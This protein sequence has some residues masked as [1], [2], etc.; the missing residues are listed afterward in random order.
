[1]RNAALVLVVALAACALAPAAGHAQVF[2]ISVGLGGGPS[3]PLGYLADEVGTG[4]NVQGTLALEVPLL[5]IGVRADLL[6]QQLPGETTGTHRQMAALAN[7]SVAMPLL[8]IRPYVIGGAGFYRARLD[9]PGSADREWTADTGVNLGVGVRV[10]LLALGVFGE[11]RL[12]N[13]FT[14]GRGTRFVP[15]TVGITF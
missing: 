10:N 1:M 14:E 15:V 5:P 4:F 7:V 3:T 12:H 9:T 8:L 6:F 13:V 2:P 11:A